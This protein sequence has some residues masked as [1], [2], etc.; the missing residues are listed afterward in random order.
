MLVDAGVEIPVIMI[1]GHADI[2]MAV[3]AMSRGAYTFLEKPFRLD[4]L[5]QQIKGS[6]QQDCVMRQKKSKRI[7][8]KSRLSRLTAKETEVLEMI[9]QGLTN[10]Q[11]AERLNLT[12]RTVEDRR[13]RL[14][15]KVEVSSLAELFELA[16][17]ARD[18]KA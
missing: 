3:T 11:M 7:D 17:T 2:S 8:A 10:K 9:H 6:I 14:M 4:V 5:Q 1:S 16:F 12:V 13:S 15:K 18:E